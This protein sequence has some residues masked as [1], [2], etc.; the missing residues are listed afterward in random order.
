LVAFA[1]A[2]QTRAAQTKTEIETPVRLPI[3][4]MLDEVRRSFTI[5]EKPV[6]PEIFRDMGDRDLADAKSILVSVDVNAAVGSN[7]YADPI[8]DLAGWR[9]Q[10]NGKGEEAGYRFIGATRNGLLI[11][12]TRYSGGGSGTFYTLHVLDV[13]PAKAFDLNGNPYDR[14]NLSTIRAI[15]LGDR[16]S[17][18][19]KISGNLLQIQ[20][21]G[22]RGAVGENR[23]RQVE[24][25]RP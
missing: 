15:P 12:L 3:S 24:V 8:S 11:V 16:W 23:P 17:G 21:T 14:I 20:T 22:G 5:Q 19:V 25:R 6:P 9:I 2:P 7:F 13:A 4:T 18:D 10:K 1:L